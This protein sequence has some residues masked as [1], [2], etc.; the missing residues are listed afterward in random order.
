M[1]SNRKIF[2][3]ELLNWKAFH[4]ASVAISDISDYRGFN[5]VYRGINSS[6]PTILA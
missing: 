1:Y 3:A 5:L 2:E 4:R 6:I